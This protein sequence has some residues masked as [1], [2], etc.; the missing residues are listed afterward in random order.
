[1]SNV[2]GKMKSDMKKKDN[3][4]TDMNKYIKNMVYD[5]NND[6]KKKTNE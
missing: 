5:F 4:I 3:E 6:M 1:M 2:I